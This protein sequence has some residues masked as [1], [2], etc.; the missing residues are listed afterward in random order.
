MSSL[1]FYEKSYNLMR[2]PVAELSARLG[3]VLFPALAAIQSE[4]GRFRA[5]FRKTLLSSS[6]IGTPL[7]ATL[8]VLGGPA[9][10]TMY[11][12]RWAPAIV[13]FQLLCVSGPLRITAQL[14]TS[15]ID[16][17][18]NLGRDLRRRFVGLGIL[19]AAVFIGVRWGLT[20]VAFAV[21]CTNITTFL[22]L[23]TLLDRVTPLRMSDVLRPQVRPVL[24]TFVLVAVEVL[25]A[26][27]GASRAWPPAVVL[28]L[29]SAA[30]GVVYAAAIYVM[31]DAVL[32]ALWHE[33]TSDVRSAFAAARL[34]RSSRRS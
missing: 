17:C 1:G 6:L 10:L 12:P 32:T 18:G 2:M 4:T 15:A 30:G 26:A 27:V 7:F 9:I 14:C 21:L 28:V 34:Q 29:G 16:A 8:V 13:P 31:R 19:I 22:L 11:G 3:V 25:I 33:L 20:G 5:A 24:G 23:I